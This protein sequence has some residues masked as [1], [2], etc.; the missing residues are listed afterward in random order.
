MT[1]SHRSAATTNQTTNKIEHQI[2][3]TESAC[4]C[5]AYWSDTYTLYYLMHTSTCLKLACKS[6]KSLIKYTRV[7]SFPLSFFVTILSKN[8]EDILIP[9]VNG[10]FRVIWLIAKYS[11]FVA[12]VSQE[13]FKNYFRAKVIFYKPVFVKYLCPFMCMIYVR[14]AGTKQSS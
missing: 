3:Y 10:H 4:C 6:Q 2:I 7:C 8:Y 11:N 5:I 13:W 12:G 1:T 14:A 9:M